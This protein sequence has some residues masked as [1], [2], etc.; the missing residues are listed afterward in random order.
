MARSAKSDAHLLTLSANWQALFIAV[1][2]IGWLSMITAMLLTFSVVHYFS[3]GT[4][5]FQITVWLQPLAFFIV[6]FLLLGQYRPAVKRLFMACLASTIGMTL[7]GVVAM[8]EQRLW[9]NYTALHPIAGNDTSWWSAF[10][11]DWVMML[12]GLAVFTGGL[13]LA[14]RKSRR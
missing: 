2:I 11:N 8:W 13:Y 4:W 6:A 1:T 9:F 10:G 5:A 14:T 12:V 3:A 7:Y